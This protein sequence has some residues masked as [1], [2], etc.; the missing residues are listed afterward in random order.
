M[1]VYRAARMSYA[2]SAMPGREEQGQG[3]P[4]SEQRSGEHISQAPRGS[5]TVLLVE[6]E[7]PIRRV[8]ARELRSLGYQVLEAADGSEAC[9]RAEEH[10]EKVDLVVCD[11]MMPGA[12]GPEVAAHVQALHPEARVLFVTGYSIDLLA[13]LGI[14]PCGANFLRKP[15]SPLE[16]AERVRAALD[17]G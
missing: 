6:D 9:R 13:R 1:A 2:R 4:P 17:A 5:E 11:V 7:A 12:L 8:M 14:D 3:H 16:L 10:P 15:F